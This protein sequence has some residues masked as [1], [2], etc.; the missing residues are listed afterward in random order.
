MAQCSPLGN[1]WAGAPRVLPPS[2]LI[3]WRN[4]SSSFFR[5]ARCQ[6]S[7]RLGAGW[8]LCFL[9]WAWEGIHRLAQDSAL[10]VTLTRASIRKKVGKIFASMSMYYLCIF[11]SRPLQE[12]R[13]AVSLAHQ[14]HLPSWPAGPQGPCRKGSRSQ[15]CPGTELMPRQIR[16]ECV[17]AAV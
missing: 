5:I 8:S 15:G 17:N 10:E 1:Q 12:R 7:V 6:V 11:V 2:S 14:A 4:P 3:W 9:Q 16:V 13:D